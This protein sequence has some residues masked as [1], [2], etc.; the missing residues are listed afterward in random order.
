MPNWWSEH[1]RDLQYATRMDEDDKNC[2]YGEDHVRRSVV[3]TREDMI[4]LVSYL[5]FANKQLRSILR[6]FCILL[7]LIVTAVTR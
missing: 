5:I 1:A 6:F 4:L 3:H 7:V 2:D